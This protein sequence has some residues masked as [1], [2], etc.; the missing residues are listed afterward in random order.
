MR[1]AVVSYHSSPLDQPGKGDSGGMN[2]Y[3]RRLAS[4]LARLG[5][6][7][8]VLTRRSSIDQADIVT[9]EPNFRVFNVTAGDPS[10]LPKEELLEYVPNFTDAALEV[11]T[12]A[13]EESVGVVHANYWL[14]G[15]V[16]HSLKHELDV[17]LFT[18]FHTLER[19]KQVG[20]ERPDDGVDSRVRIINEQ[21][22]M[23]CS[24]AIIVSC[25]PEARWVSEL[26]RVQPA[27]VR[28]VPLG[29]DTAFFTPGTKEMARRA[30]GLP[31]GSKI[32][33]AIGRIQPLKGF[34]LAVEA[35]GA[36]RSQFDLHL[37]IVG[38]PSGIEGVEEYERLVTIARELGVSDRLHLVDPQAHELLSSYY[39]ACDVVVIPS[40][41]ESF[42]LVALEAAAS[43]RPVVASAVGG[44]VSLVRHRRSGLLVPER[45]VEDF[46]DAL[47]EILASDE[48]A[49]LM[50]AGGLKVS[51]G[52]TWKESAR[53]FLDVVASLSSHELL[54]C[55]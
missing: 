45:T 24:D 55:G 2:V 38:G 54:R 25:E 50:G 26:Y 16:G 42:G 30:I 17:P 49:S 1:I 18:S 3:V 29:V 47:S 39:R 37:V 31:L 41:T 14:S 28:T 53:S 9:V 13:G 36:L 32:M 8:D 46:R 22:A 4:A 15:I 6:Q 27:Q 11:L 23:S 21:R 43:G 19:V 10:P 44:L 48:R 5:V 35:L 7:C 12:K 34:T 40:R 52:F 33:L 51:S 20:R